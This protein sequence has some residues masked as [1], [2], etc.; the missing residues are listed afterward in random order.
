VKIRFAVA[1]GASEVASFHRE[2]TEI[3]SLGFDTVW[4]SDLPLGPQVDPLVGLAFAA[5]VTTKLKLGANVVPLGRNPLSLAKSLAQ[6]DQISAGRLL[7]SFVVGIDQ[8]GERL[9]LGADGVN[10]GD[11]VEE[12]TPLL[13]AWWAGDAV[14]HEWGPYTFKDVASPARSVQQPLEVWFGGSG[15]AAL[16]RA[17]R[18]ADGWLGSFMTPSEAGSARR[19]IQDAAETAGRTI[20]PE[21]FGLSVPYAP[22]AP[23]ARTLQLLKARRPDADAAA[24]VPVGPDGLRRLLAAHVDAGVSKFVVRPVGPGAGDAGMLEDLAAI[25]LPL[26]T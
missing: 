6:I 4:L 10:R 21:H 5:G 13:R 2:V 15:P 18:A 14:S 23:D 25:V 16:A 9:A 1:A 26:Q 8:P 3:E 7:L 24:L 22:V 20:D 17:G 12:L 11:R 19:R